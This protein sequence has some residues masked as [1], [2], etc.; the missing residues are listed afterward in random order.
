MS[1]VN[2]KSLSNFSQ[3]DLLDILKEYIGMSNNVRTILRKDNRYLGL[4][5]YDVMTEMLEK[6][7]N[8]MVGQPFA[9]HPFHLLFEH[10]KL[11][12]LAQLSQS[13]NRVDPAPGYR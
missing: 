5:I 13:Q 4:E 8:N 10:K 2:F 3:E 6:Q 9:I 1:Y 7:K 12:S 11:L